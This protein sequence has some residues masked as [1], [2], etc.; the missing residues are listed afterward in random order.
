MKNNSSKY[1]WDRKTET[2]LQ[3]WPEKSTEH[4]LIK[5]TVP[6]EFVSNTPSD[7]ITFPHP[8]P[9]KI[10][11]GRGIHH[12]AISNHASGFYTQRANEEFN[13]VSFTTGGSANL[14]INGKNINL[15]KG[16][17]FYASSKSEYTLQIPKYW[18]MFFFHL[19]KS[20]KWNFIT[21]DIYI[22]RNANFLEEIKYPTY[23]FFDE[24]YKQNRSL[25]LLEIYADMLEIYIRREITNNDSHWNRLDNIIYELQ[26]S[27]IQ[28]ISTKG[29]AQQLGMNVYKFDKHCIKFHGMKFAKLVE[30][31]KMQ[32]GKKL[33]MSLENPNITQIAKECGYANVHSF[34]RAFSRYFK[35]TPTSFIEKTKN[36]S[37]I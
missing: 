30:Q 18:N 22:V 31:I 23:K 20:P 11:E 16:M 36:T 15:K 10:L 26:T 27:S 8:L 7:K 9:I 6:L 34:S 3:F 32:K 19:E 4:S 25:R 5:P 2:A 14:K 33:L 37:L 17:L 28:T 1:L 35:E 24:V 21:K 29:A 12:A 13:Y